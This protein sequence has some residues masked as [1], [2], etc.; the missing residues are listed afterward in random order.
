MRKKQDNLWGLI[1][2][3][4]QYNEKFIMDIHE[5]INNIIVFFQ[6][7]P[8]VAIAITIVAIFFIYRYPKFFFSLFLLA[9]LLSFIFFAISNLASTSVSEKEKLLKKDRATDINN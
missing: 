8:F 5:I 7:A 1:N 4:I 9:L 3:V 2:H 6:N